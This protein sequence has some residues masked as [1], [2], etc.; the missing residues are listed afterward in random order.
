MQ[1]LQKKPSFTRNNC[2][3]RGK[4]SFETGNRIGSC[5][6]TLQKSN[7]TLIDFV[8]RLVKSNPAFIQRN[9]TLI[10]SNP[11]FLQLLRVNDD[12]F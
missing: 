7:P 5:Y 1:I 6:P 11:G 2:K 10:K 3:K 12:F 9:P 4:D 8:P